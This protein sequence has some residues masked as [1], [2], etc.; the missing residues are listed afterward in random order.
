MDQANT[1]ES[2]PKKQR[3][4][5]ETNKAARS[6]LCRIMRER[7]N[8]EIDSATFRDLVYGFNVLLSHDKHLHEK[9]LSNRIEALET[10]LKGTGQTMINPKDLDNPYI[11]DLKNRLAEM[12]E[13]KTNSELRLM[14]VEKELK[15]LKAKLGDQLE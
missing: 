6:S 2:T 8:K 10:I 7:R 1:T 12:Q 4:G 15:L 11:T 9:E 14:E 5:L 13:L 3:F